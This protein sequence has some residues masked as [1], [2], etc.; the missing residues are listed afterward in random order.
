MRDDV[1][2]VGGGIVGLATALRLLH[3]RP[4][5]RVVV[6]EKEPALA[7]HQ[8]GH[9]SGVIHSGIYY[10]P[11]SLKATLCRAGARATKAFAAEH[12]LAVETCGKL[13]VA[14]D[15]R[16]LARLDA[17]QERAAVNGIVVERLDAAA[18]QRREP[19]VVGRGALFVAETGIVDYVAVAEAMAADVRALGGE[20]RT[21]VRVTEIDE[22]TD[23]VDVYSDH[24]RW[25]VG[26]LVVCGGLQA[27]RLARAAGLEPDFRIVPFRGEYHR[28]PAERQDL[29][30]HLIYPVPDPDLPFL[31][32]HLTRTIDGGITVGPN[33]VLGLAR[34][35]YAKWSV[36][37]RDVRDALAFPGLRHVARRHL[38][39][40]LRELVNSASRRGYLRE[41]R[42][43]C[44]TLTV[45]DLLPEPAGIRAQAVLRDGTLVHDFLL[46]RTDRTLHVA[47]AP[48][49]AAT[50]ALPIGQ[51]I[52]R[53]LLTG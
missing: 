22:R 47:N 31:G 15:E 45:D 11:G 16:E 19:A 34:E 23:H 7:T 1:G 33:A 49:P 35:G 9:N 24:E 14:T 39:T 13:I 17:L 20:I 43:Y 6:L 30:R 36:D 12:G 44:P 2:V 25:R 27:D 42:K 26:R 38:R 4:G 52:A 18:L 48:S 37:R 5:T 53:A 51:H 8:T 41:C 50:S 46:L 10:E 28:L 21:G 3:D 29:V 40:G 32:I